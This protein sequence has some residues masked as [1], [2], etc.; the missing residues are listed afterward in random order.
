MPSVER[1]FDPIGYL[2][3]RSGSRFVLG[4]TGPPGAGKSTFANWLVSELGEAAI[5][6]PMDG[7][8]FP[9]T[10]LDERGLLNR[11]GAPDTYDVAGFLEVLRGLRSREVVLSPSYSRVTHE[12]ER[13]AIRILPSHR[14]VVVEGNYL[15]VPNS[16]WGEVKAVLDEVWYLDISAE[17][18]AERLVGRH[19]DVGRTFDVA[20]EK[21]RS[22][23]LPNGEIVRAT[24][25]R[26]DR[27][28]A[29]SKS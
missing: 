29:A 1:E 27:W 12:P 2:L 10:E 16:P 23:D 28:M 24:R 19:M 17:E 6:L 20:A 3:G 21:V 7:F 8:H 18:A 15:L 26:A 11:K 9:N 13:D 25:D 4:I 5:V 22:V 14:F